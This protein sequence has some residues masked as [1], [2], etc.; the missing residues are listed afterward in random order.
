MKSEPGF[1]RAVLRNALRR[2]AL[3]IALLGSAA[4]AGVA[5]Q[6]RRPRGEESDAARAARD[7][8]S[9]LASAAQPA[10]SATADRSIAVLMRAKRD[11]E[12]PAEEEGVLKLIPVVEG[13]RVKEGELLAQ[14]DVRRPQAAVKVASLQSEVAHK[15]SQDDVEIRY[16]QAAA[17]YAWVDWERDVE[18]NARVP[19]AVPDIQI[20]Q[21]RLAYV[22]A[23][24]QIEKAEKDHD[25]AGK[26]A[27]AKLA[28]MEA[29]QLAVDLRTIFAPFDGE[30]VTLR[31]EQSEW[32]SPG[33]PIL[34][35]VQF[36]VLYAEGRVPLKDYDPI[37]LRGKKTTVEAALPNGRKASVHGEVIYVSPMIDGNQEYMIRAE[38]KNQQDQGE[39]LIRLGMSASMTLSP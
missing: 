6:D 4:A 20:R 18:T 9:G 34:R 7:A 15:R 38:I 17:N 31:K 13:S 19:N 2:S 3:G 14:M 30:V 24:L 10:S 25:L 11:V 26:E 23:K 29:A 32:A 28:E 39:W 1:R 8:S 37:E 35:L 5:S 33:E 12:I 27:E 22:R 21:K 36:D 16:A